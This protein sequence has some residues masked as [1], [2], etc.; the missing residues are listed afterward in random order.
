VL[1]YLNL[2]GIPAELLSTAEGAIPADAA[3]AVF[4]AF[5]TL[6]EANFSSVSGVFANFSGRDGVVFKLTLENLRASIPESME[7][8]LSDAGVKFEFEYE[9]NVTYACFTLP[10]GGDAV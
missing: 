3:L 10:S 6:L 4:E 1:R 5:K 9:D 8:K 7:E 2:C